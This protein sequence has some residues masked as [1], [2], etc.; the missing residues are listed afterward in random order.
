MNKHLT[1]FIGP[2]FLVLTIGC[3]GIGGAAWPPLAIGAALMVM[4]FAAQVL[5]ER[6]AVRNFP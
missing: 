6:A 3:P 5:H 1:E 4:S 2:L